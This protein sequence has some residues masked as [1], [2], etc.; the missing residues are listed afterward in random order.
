M[1]KITKAQ[2]A[3]LMGVSKRTFEKLYSARLTDVGLGGPKLYD[4]NEVIA[5]ANSIAETRKATKR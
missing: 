1:T 4:A 3:V 2:A 5:L